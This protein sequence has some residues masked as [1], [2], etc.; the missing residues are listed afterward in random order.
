M[1]LFA[2]VVSTCI[3]CVI[4]LIYLNIYYDVSCQRLFD[5]EDYQSLENDENDED[6]YSLELK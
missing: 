3:L 4:F 6:D 5:K 1:E 2:P